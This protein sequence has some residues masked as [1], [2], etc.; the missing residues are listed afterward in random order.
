[1]PS[2]MYR[3][4]EDERIDP[5]RRRGLLW[6]TAI[7]GILAGTIAILM[8]LLA[9]FAA[10]YA[11]AALLL[12]VG[13]T[14]VV[15]SFRDGGL[16]RTAGMI[17]MGLVGIITAILLIAFPIIGIIALT[18]LL[19]AYLIASGLVKTYQS[20]RMRPQGGWGWML[21]GGIASLALGI[22]LFFLLP[23]ASFFVLGLFVGIDMLF[24]SFSL[25]GLLLGT[26][27][28]RSGADRPSAEEGSGLVMPRE[29]AQ[30]QGPAR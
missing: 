26:R 13:V 20:F 2:M 12:A 16:G 23:E 10:N 4:G 14:Q 29:D 15:V 18:T 7:A 5:T 21:A 6:F 24:Y 1:M 19:T 11:F 17:L 28:D 9:T 22:V 27:G 3:P 8:P 30:E 25:L